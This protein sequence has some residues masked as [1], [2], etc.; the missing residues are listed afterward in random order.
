[1]G[2]PQETAYF[3]CFSSINMQRRKA[4]SNSRDNRTAAATAKLWLDNRT[5]A[6]TKIFKLS[7]N[8][9]SGVYGKEHCEP[10]VVIDLTESYRPNKSPT[11]PRSLLV[12]EDQAPT[13]GYYVFLSLFGGPSKASIQR[14]IVVV[15]F[16]NN[17]KSQWLYLLP[18]RKQKINSENLKFDYYFNNSAKGILTPL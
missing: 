5:A 15:G 18:K 11:K 13:N 1:M 10:K 3:A 14:I 17:M 4:T 9:C 12:S 8:V 16:Y 6:A 7:T 2:E